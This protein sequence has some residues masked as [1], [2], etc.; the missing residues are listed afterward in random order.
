MALTGVRLHSRSRRAGTGLV[1]AAAL[2]FAALL[3][4]APPGDAQ[5]A[6]VPGE[7]AETA[8]IDWRQEYASDLTGALSEA[9]ESGRPLMIVFR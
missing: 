9:R 6:A 4:A 5:E 2:T 8:T 7:D 1:G 3:A